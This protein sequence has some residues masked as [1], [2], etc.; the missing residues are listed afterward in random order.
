MN[1]L[2][3][4]IGILSLMDW[5]HPSLVFAQERQVRHGE[6]G[7]ALELLQSEKTL[8]PNPMLKRPQTELNP[9]EHLDEKTEDFDCETHCK[10]R[11]DLSITERTKCETLCQKRPDERFPSR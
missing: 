3:V 10:N 8:P 2:C 7:S 11:N 5:F 9:T 6:P 4:S 1:W